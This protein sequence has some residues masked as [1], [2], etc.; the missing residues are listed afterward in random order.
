[1]IKDIPL[2]LSEWELEKIYPSNKQEKVLGEMKNETKE[3]S[4]KDAVKQI[5]DFIES[6][7]TNIFI[8]TW[9]AWTWKTTI[10]KE[11][12]NFLIKNNKS[13]QI[14]TPTWKATYNL[15]SRIEN[16]NS[17]KIST[18]FSELYEK[19]N[20]VDIKLKDVIFFET[21]TLDKDVYIVDEAWLIWLKIHKDENQYQKNVLNFWSW[22]LLK[23]IIE[24]LLDK[25]KI[26][27]VWDLFQLLPV[28]DNKIFALDNNFYQSLNNEYD[29]KIYLQ[30]NKFD[31]NFVVKTTLNF[32]TDNVNLIKNYR[33]ENWNWIVINAE[34]IKN[35]IIKKE[36]SN[37]I[38]ENNETVIIKDKR[39]FIEKLKE[40]Y[41]NNE[42]NIIISYTNN[43]ILEYNKIIRDEILLYKNIIEIWEKLIIS[44]NLVVN[45]ELFFNWEIVEVISINWEIENHRDIF[46]SNWEKTEKIDLK[47]LDVNLKKNIWNEI[48]IFNFKLCLNTL[49]SN[50]NWSWE[51][52]N[53]WKFISSF[54]DI[55]MKEKWWNVKTIN[56]KKFFYKNEEAK[57]DLNILENENQEYEKIKKQDEY[58]N[59]LHA[60]YWYAITCHK[61]QW[62]EWNNIFLD[63]DSYSQWKTNENFLRFLYTWIT[64][65]KN[66][67]YILNNDETLINDTKKYDDIATG[68]GIEKLFIKNY[69]NK[70]QNVLKKNN[71][72]VL[73]IQEFNYQIQIIFTNWQSDWKIWFYYNWKNK[74]TTKQSINDS[75]FNK[76]IIQILNDNKL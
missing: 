52:I 15:S 69:I 55:K 31:E 21:K 22:S 61:S 38:E 35:W 60:N 73:W 23:D 65:A 58:Y 41:K 39:L 4:Q 42:Q 72:F 49:N 11:I 68:F 20:S 7:D 13:F 51:D 40:N 45:D 36:Y 37:L 8:L 64:R 25:T 32:K 34:N 59:S 2:E 66:K 24:N 33:Q 56:K 3:I 9:W 16:I 6:E 47:F 10:I 63:L 54:V 29:K 18:I 50:D 76:T 67:V 26:I 14:T 12:Y 27:F 1:M 62:S 57:E 43:S 71:Y 5:I 17:D 28:W 30:Q 74:F 44:K 53:I 70:I 46:V 48:K 19:Y 75:W